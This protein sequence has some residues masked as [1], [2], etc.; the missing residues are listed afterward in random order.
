MPVRD[1][2]RDAQRRIAAL[3]AACARAVAK[4]NRASAQRAEVLAGQ[5]RLVAIARKEVQRTV[6]AMA[7]AVG[8]QLTANLLGLDPADVR[9]LVKSG[10]PARDSSDPEQ[11][12][13]RES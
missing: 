13:S 12:T 11:A 7:D 6:A 9:R 2:V 8:A 3:D 5:E 4:L 1:A 10:A